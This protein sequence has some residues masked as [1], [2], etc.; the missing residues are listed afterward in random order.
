MKRK[1]CAITALLMLVI[2]PFV[3]VAQRQADDATTQLQKLNRFYRYLHGMYVDSVA[4]APIVESAIRGMLEELDPHS[5]YLDAEE[6]K[7]AEETMQG[8]FS[9]IGIEYNIHN[10]SIIVVNTI[11]QGPADKA[12]LQPNDRIVEIDGDNVVGISRNEVPPKLR[13][14]R[15]STVRIGVARHGV[16]EILPFSIVRDNIP[17]NSIDAVFKQ[18]S[19]G[20]IKVN[21][22]ERNTMR[23]FEEAMQ[24]LGQVES[25]ILDLCGNGGGLLDQAIDMAGY[26]LPP[27][28]L[29][30]SIE[31]RAVMPEQRRSTRGGLFNGRLVVLIDGNSA[32]G[33]ELVAGAIQDWDRGV[34]VGKHSFG[35]GLVQRQVPMGDGSAIRLTIARYHTP[36]GRV[37]QRPYERG[38]KEEYYRAHT[39]RLLGEQSDSVVTD[40]P[41]YK[42]LLS[43]RTVYGGGGIEPDIQVESDT[44]DVSDY[45]VRVMAQGVENEFLMDYLDKN[46]SRLA[47]DYPTFESFE[48]SFKLSDE[49]LRQMTALASKKGV[50]FDEAGFNRSRTLMQHRLTAMIAQRLFSSTEFYRYMNSR[51]NQYYIKAMEVLDN[52]S[53]MGEKTLS[54]QTD[55]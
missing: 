7:A 30:T 29:I 21:R 20:Y 18:G 11:V 50:E 51:E 53:E 41:A 13:G 6:M 28:T 36:S 17:I 55:K 3:A 54:A 23:E 42:T 14:E 49:E 48:S 4:M 46:R 31:G 8:S 47:A 9:G 32:S 10:D 37:I 25:L 44:T 24:Q 35:K 34:F 33:S 27:R 40:R 22:F 1:V 19:T 43:G 16:K 2:A 39:S 12:G 45:M 52:W 38:Q 15:G 26:F 5:A